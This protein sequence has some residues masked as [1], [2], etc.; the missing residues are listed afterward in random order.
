MI[1]KI[2]TMDF[3]QWYKKSIE[4][5]PEDPPEGLWESIQN[6]L[7]INDVWIR[8]EADLGTPKRT[9]FPLLLTIAASFLFIVFLGSCST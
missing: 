8:L 9:M 1:N 2:V 5:Q 3:N 4:T 7:D 6:D